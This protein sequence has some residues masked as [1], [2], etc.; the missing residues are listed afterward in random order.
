MGK[1]DTEK[2]IIIEN[3]GKVGEISY[4]IVECKTHMRDFKTDRTPMNHTEDALRQLRKHISSYSTQKIKVNKAI[5]VINT[6]F[7]DDMEKKLRSKKKSLTQWGCE[8]ILIIGIN[9]EIEILLR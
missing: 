3:I 1:H 5:L 9:R 8:S 4:D 6:L 2:D 7:T